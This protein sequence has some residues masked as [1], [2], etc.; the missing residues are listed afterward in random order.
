MS[1][2][3]STCAGVAQVVSRVNLLRCEHG[4]H[5]DSRRAY[6]NREKPAPPVR[7]KVGHLIVHDITPRLPKCLA[8]ND[9]TRLLALDLEQDAALKQV[10]E[11]RPGMAVRR[12]TGISGRQL[13]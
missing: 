10:A 11:H 7:I 9:L 3:V 6:A 8:G 1:V 12:Q 13:D 2:A 4:D 5:L